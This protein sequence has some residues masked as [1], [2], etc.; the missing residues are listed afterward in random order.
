ML[1]AAVTSNTALHLAL[2]SALLMG[3]RHGFDYD[4]VAA[5][6]DIAAAESSG[7]KAL[8]LGMIYAG[9]HAVMVALL[10]TA[11]LL[12]QFRLPEG[13]DVIAEHL[14]GATLV[15][16]G[17]YVVGTLL[18]GPA[19]VRPR[20]RGQML[21]GASMWVYQKLRRLFGSTP[22]ERVAE[23]A[24]SYGSGSAFGIGVIHGIGAET[25]TQIMIFLLAANLGGIRNGVLGL[26]IF[27]VGL[28]L[29][30]ALI[31]ASATG[32]L[33]MS[34]D[35]PNLNRLLTGC[36]ASFSVVLGLYYLVRN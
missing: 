17:A 20:S 16:L 1:D 5:I 14:V 26:A 34:T 18:F 23:S 4:H 24:P 7:K 10:G 36:A 21:A 13:T 30:N 3:L 32:L 6:S 35:R 2:A 31:C 9:G 11:A 19:D 27:L 22:Q 12:F 28:M 25:P 29:M 33:K 8:R 15:L